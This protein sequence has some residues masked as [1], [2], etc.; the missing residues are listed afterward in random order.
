MY[1]AQSRPLTV[2]DAL[3]NVATTVYDALGRAAAQVDPLGNVS[4]TVYD[5]AGRMVAQVDPLGYRTS[6]G[7][8]GANRQVSVR[9]ASGNVT[10]TLY[11]PAGHQ[12][13]SV[14]ALGYRTSYL[15]DAAG[16]QVAVQ[17]A[18]GFLTTKVYDG[19]GRVIAK[20]DAL[21]KHT[22]LVYDR[23]N[24]V[25][26]SLDTNG[27]STTAVYDAASRQ[28]AILDA[29][30][31]FTTLLYDGLARQIALVNASGNRTTSLYDSRGDLL[32]TRD[33]L[34]R[35]TSYA[36]DGAGNRVQRTDARGQ[37][38]T[39]TLDALNRTTGVLHADSL[40]F[41]FTFDAI[42]QQTTMWDATGITTY[43]YDLEGRQTVVSG[44]GIQGTLTYTYDP[45]GNRLTLNDSL[46]NVNT[47]SYDAQDR[48]VAVLD[49]HTGNTTL[50]YD[51]LDRELTRTYLNGVTTSHSYD[52]SGRV[53]V[54]ATV[55]PVGSA[56]AV[57]TSMY[58]GVG[59]RLSMQELDGSRMTYSYDVSYQLVQEQRS[60]A[61][62]YST[63]YVYDG[64]GNRLTK[65]DSGAVTTYSYDA[66]DA[67][68]MVYPPTG[69]P[70][71]IMY[72]AN[73]NQTLENAGGV[74]TRYAW[75][76][77]NRLVGV[78]SALGVE[79]YTYNAQNH[80]V[81]KATNIS[82][83]DGTTTSVWDGENLVE[84]VSANASLNAHYAQMPSGWGGLL[85][86]WSGGSRHYY[87][88][89]PAGNTRVLATDAGS[90]A[91]SYL[92]KAF[93]E[94]LAAGSN[95]LNP[96]RFGGQWGYYRDEY[97]QGNG[98]R[99][100]VRARYLDTTKS[101]WISKDPLG[102]ASSDW[103]FYRY[104]NN[105]P[106][107]K[108]DPSG[109]ACL[110]GKLDPFCVPD[111]PNSALSCY[112]CG[113]DV[114]NSTSQVLKD[115]AS[116]FRSWSFLRR[117]LKCKALT[118]SP[119]SWQVIATSWDIEELKKYI[120]VPSKCGISPQCQGS[121]AVQGTCHCSG[122]VNYLT[123]GVM[124]SLCALADQ[125]YGFLWELDNAVS[126][127]WSEAAMNF[128]ITQWKQY[129]YHDKKGAKYAT[130][131]ADIGYEATFG[132]HSTWSGKAIAPPSKTSCKICGGAVDNSSFTYVW[133][134]IRGGVGHH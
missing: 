42:G 7:Y 45:V 27:N 107:N 10:T 22:T 23:N 48:V 131:W 49:S 91:D 38:T 106:N 123:Y 57:Y 46:G 34:G 89:D 82:G 115:I 3:G 5:A 102:L 109:M 58:D 127:G 120:N 113:P 75:D 2:T 64:P 84:E 65:N 90:I 87:V 133:E 85:G 73:G 116:D 128:T 79:T 21:S 125:K 39:Y 14:T 134:D 26:T 96:L 121:V 55:G 80:R 81:L 129:C 95:T 78:S 94:E 24:R 71:T 41:T 72:D 124:M 101:K 29:R 126:L 20:V 108:I 103:N 25:L 11:D 69:A 132:F 119:I 30:G 43:A 40:Q 60:G 15:Y 67:V 51:S 93:G 122:F 86:Q 61:N 56:L 17:D 4:S 118:L 12:Q 74:Q 28:V 98:S 32:S 63:S 47:Y 37:V 105:A 83:F 13:A 114:T 54:L 117:Y 110:G 88:F 104:V 62:A 130:A 100:Y 31:Y 1:D 52:P 53:G 19:S 70:T 66:A 77:E 9:D 16:R 97:N 50:T 33:P 92:Y 6:F 59:N 36:Y 18:L 68:T 8:D 76:G 112:T 99:L 44:P 111:E 35:I